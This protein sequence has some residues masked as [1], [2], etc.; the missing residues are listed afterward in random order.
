MKVNEVCATVRALIEVEFDVSSDVSPKEVAEEIKCLIE[1]WANERPA[2]DVKNGDKAPREVASEWCAESARH[3]FA[4]TAINQRH[5]VS[6]LGKGASFD[7]LANEPRLTKANTLLS[8][9][10]E[11]Y[12]WVSRY[13]PIP[14]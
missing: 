5:V 4:L 10:A 7:D 2:R 12:E 6:L 14:E 9:P 1:K 13:S 11:F 8:L 3:F